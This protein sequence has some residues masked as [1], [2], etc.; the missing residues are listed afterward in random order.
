MSDDI[1]FCQKTKCR[2]TSCFRHV[3]NMHDRT[4]PHSFFVETPP[5]CPKLKHDNNHDIYHIR[6]K[7]LEDDG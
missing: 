1:S 2:R 5:D 6:K 3:K 4:I 7:V